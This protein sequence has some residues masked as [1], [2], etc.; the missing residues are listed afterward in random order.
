MGNSI[1]YTAATESNSLVKG[2]FRIGTGDVGKGPTSSTGFYQ[3]S[4]PPSGGY[5]VYSYNTAVS[6]NIAYYNAANDSD[7]INYTNRTFGQSFTGVSQCLVYYAGQTDKTCFNREYEPIVT[8]G[9]LLH[10]DAGFVPSYPTSGNTWYDISGNNKNGT[11]TNGPTF[12]TGNGG[13]ISFDGTDDVV[14][15]TYQTGQ[16]SAVSI[17]LWGY[18]LSNK[19]LTAMGAYVDFNIFASYGFGI[20]VGANGTAFFIIPDVDN[21]DESYGTCSTSQNGWGHWVMVYD[22]TQTGGTNRLKVYYNGSQQSMTI[23]HGTIPSTTTTN[24]NFQLGKNPIAAGFSDNSK[25]AISQVYNRALSAAEVLQ[26]YN[27]QKARFG[28]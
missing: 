6:G 8:N 3:A 26:N 19:E 28:L 4:A 17:A 13:S 14:T 16:I 24:S 23:S 5:R 12:D 25:I 18:K 22:G 10:L 7:L 11:L 27:A 9:L 1:K 15:T 20:E 2:N 21:F